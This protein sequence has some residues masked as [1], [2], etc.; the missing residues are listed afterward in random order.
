MSP[1]F[2]EA[3]ERFEAENANDPRKELVG[4]EWVP[5]E[6]LYARRLAG[7]VFKLEP[8]ASEVLQL[9]ARSQHIRR[10]EIPRNSFPA[11]KKGYHRWRARLKA[12]T[13]RA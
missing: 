13:V 6:L 5:G 3:I 9:A 10:W 2:H 8:N 7:W 11:D 12:F 4:G 1:R